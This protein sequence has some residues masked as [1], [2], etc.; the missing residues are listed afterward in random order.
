M[1]QTATSN[2][3]L[4]TR[5]H[6]GDSAAETELVERYTRGVR[7]MLMKRTGDAFLARDCCNEALMLVLQKL[8]SGE[9]DKPESLP[10]FIR[11]T[12]VNISIQ[13][14]RKEKRYIGQ[15]SG[16][17]ELLAAHRDRKDQELDSQ[18]I[19]GV[20]EN[21]LDQLAVPRDREILR[22]FYLRDEDKEQICTALELS[23]VH[24]D[25][26]LYR[27]KKRM[28]ELIN[29]QTKLKSI[30]FGALFDG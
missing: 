9:I 15:E 14:F 8:R 23:A 7:L 2:T 27:A 18:K 20:L 17:I 21:A 28:K 26:V 13:Y 24:F 22:R 1:Q 29:Q 12:A 5:I 6:S 3:E 16:R 30:L 19:R 25:R 4:A 10:A 11:Q